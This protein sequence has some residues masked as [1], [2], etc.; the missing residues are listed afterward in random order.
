MEKVIITTTKY[1]AY[2][3]PQL[4]TTSISK[5]GE[6]CTVSCEMIQMTSKTFKISDKPEEFSLFVGRFRTMDVKVS[7]KPK[8][9]WELAF[10]E[11]SNSH[12][13]DNLDPVIPIV[14][15]H[16]PQSGTIDIDA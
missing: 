1:N 6:M 14:K 7:P 15:T 10:D 9:N 4:S 16:I 2:G 8:G 11:E 13:W 5:V 3:K 12:Y